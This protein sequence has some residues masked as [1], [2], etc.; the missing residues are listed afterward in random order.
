MMVRPAVMHG[1]DMVPLTERQEV[2][3]EVEELKMLQYLC[4]VS[5]MNKTK[6]EY[7]R[8]IAHI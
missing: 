1:L 6:N 2:E 3:A 5:S 4:K 8:G 7:M